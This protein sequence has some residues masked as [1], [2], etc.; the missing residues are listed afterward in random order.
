MGYKTTSAERSQATSAISSAIAAFN[1]PDGSGFALTSTALTEGV[2]LKQYTIIPGTNPVNSETSIGGAVITTV[3]IT[4][5]NYTAID[6]TALAT[7]GGYIKLTGTGFK[8]GCIVYVG[9]VAATT[10]T[11]VSS[12]EVRAAIGS[13]SSNT[14]TVALA[15]PDGSAGF[16]MA[17]IDVNGVPAWSTNA[18]LTAAY[19]QASYSQTLTANSNSSIAYSLKSGSN[20]P[21]GVS[22]DPSTG[23][24]SG[25]TPADTGATTYTFTII[26]TDAEN[27]DTERLFSLTINTDTVS[28]SSP[29]AGTSY[30]ITPTVTVSNISLS[31]SALSGRAV[32]Y[33]A[34]TLPT[35]LTLSGGV[36]FGTISGSSHPAST[37]LTATNNYRPATR[38]INWNL[39]LSD[40]YFKYT[41]LLLNGESL[42]GTGN[43]WIKDSSTNNFA[44]TPIGDARSNNFSP[45]N[46][47]WSN[48]FNG[49]GDS[50][51][52]SS[53]S[54]NLGSNDFTIETWIYA[55]TTDRDAIIGSIQD[56]DGLSSWMLMLNNDGPLR[57]YARYSGGSTLNYNVGSGTF[58][59]NS[60]NHVAVTRNGANL[61][62]FLNG[63]QVGTTNTSL[64]T[65]SIDNASTLYYVARTV[66]GTAYFT[67]Y[68]SNLRVVVG[69]AL[70]T[71]T[72]TPPT[73]PL[74]AIANT[75]LLTCQSNRFVDNSTNNFAISVISTPKVVGFSPF[76][77]TD[78]LTG[79]G[80]FDGTG[81]RLTTPSNAA[82][83]LGTGDYT[84]ECWVYHTD[85]TN[86]QTYFARGT[87]GNYN[88][89][90]FY[91][92]NTTN[93]IAVYYT[94]QIVASNVVVGLNQWVHLAACRASGTLRL[95]INGT[96]VGSASD[97]TNL[98][99]SIVQVGADA[100]G[101]NGTKGYISNARVL[102]G[103]AL[104]TTTFT[105][106]TAPLTAIANTS[107][108]TLQSRQSANNN[109]FNDS[110]SGNFNVTRVG[111]PTQGT[112]T[113]FSQTG[114][115]THFT[116]TSG[117]RLTYPGSSSTYVSGTG[118]FTIEMWINID[119]ASA[120]RSRVLIE[121]DV[122]N[123]I[124]MRLGPSNTSNINGLSVSRV[125][126]A[127]NEYCNFTFEFNTWYHVAVVRAS[128]VYYFFVNGVQYTTQNVGQTSTYNFQ[129]PSLVSIGDNASYPNDE[130]YKGY[131]SNLRVSS[132]GRYTSNFTPSTTP[133]TALSNTQFLSL[134]DN[135]WVDRS[136]N[137]SAISVVGSSGTPSVQ[138][139]SPFAP[140]A[141]YSTSVVGGSGYFDGTSDAIYFQDTTQSGTSSDFNLGAGNNA[142]ID[143][144]FYLTATTAQNTAG[145]SKQ[146]SA[147]NDWNG[148]IWYQIYLHDTS[149]NISAFWR[150]GA[151]YGYFYTAAPSAYLN[152]WNH[153]AFASDT[154]NNLSLFLNGTRIL[155][156]VATIGLA[157]ATNYITFG[158]QAAGQSQSR[159]KG[160]MTG[161][162][163]IQ[164]SG[165]FNAAS[166]TITVPTAPPTV[167]AT[168][169]L[170]LNFTNAGIYDATGKNV[171]Q[172]IGSVRLSTAQYKY[173]NSSIEFDGTG[174]RL[175][176]VP[177]TSTNV[178]LGTGDFTIELWVYF[179][180]LPS[181]DLLL[182]G[183]DTNA[184]YLIAT[185][186]GAIRFGT[187][188]VNWLIGPGGTMSTGVWNHVAVTRL[189]STINLFLNGTTV[190]SSVSSAQNF[191]AASYVI[192]G[193]QVGG[194]TA[195]NGLMD[196]V[197]ITKG[198]ARY[199]TNFT[200]PTAALT[201]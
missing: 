187:Y 86:Q 55:T 47:S 23:V 117:T 108:L 155:T 116:G 119:P 130:I 30:T 175:H 44:V 38:V 50:L 195:L 125:F 168:T 59:T 60:W 92:E 118:D 172:T 68:I 174:D 33:S 89:V 198:Y 57:F 147:P 81:D 2:G 152:Q 12:T 36:I 83:T 11:F 120:G 21:A 182:V 141:A 58:P 178:I 112:F 127:D 136:T 115:G 131:I 105:P 45:Y 106:P 184:A 111:A 96:Q 160:Y 27:Q 7:T 196:D 37:L 162:R 140:T 144:W 129:V 17:G 49:S 87:A 77:E 154:S 151:N 62:I 107:L 102:K 137:A 82:F 39:V 93:Y 171:V 29:A 54:L 69:T 199:T 78:T 25:T 5:S 15:N 10:T 121:G 18:T 110:S 142:S 9:G 173:N 114:W 149:G 109:S 64:S 133:L 52:L 73:S 186:S 170:L 79:S 180:T 132:V 134:Q 135:R 28:W 113:P 6:D 126:Q 179:N 72:F 166:S 14:F 19:E 157:T 67:G 71:T 91:K 95:F 99:E 189:N 176:I 123:G 41:T 42:A 35:G 161:L 24:L 74:T 46:S 75:V 167:T 165:A 150:A 32:T 122:S 61:R 139:F 98:T 88:G 181:G 177:N 128:A 192:G 145:L 65:S 31:A 26:A 197:R 185:S 143:H 80:Y 34:N 194:T 1:N 164:G 48:S 56:S 63:V 43:T 159:F 13:N 51:S 20:L 94:S 97:T 193:D 90:Y 103:T 101:T 70:Y 124:Q 84:Y 191:S 22:L 201:L 76:T 200:P 156:T 188:N 85:L 8:T 183:G 190:A 40:L 3:A 16:Y 53:T 146:V 100:D 158:Q 66:D 104:Y 148:Q 153:I 163:F 138:A 4:D 169:K